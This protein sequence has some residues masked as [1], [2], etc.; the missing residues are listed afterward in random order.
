MIETLKDIFLGA[1]PLREVPGFIVWL[2]GKTF[3]FWIVVILAFYVGWAI[4]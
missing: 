3:W 4:K 2:I 1:L